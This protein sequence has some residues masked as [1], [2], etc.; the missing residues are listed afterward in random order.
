MKQIVGITMMVVVILLVTSLYMNVSG[1]AKSNINKSLDAD[2]YLP[3][4]VTS[5]SKHYSEE[6]KVPR[7]IVKY[8]KQFAEAA[9]DRGFYES[10]VDTGKGKLV[11]LPNPP[12]VTE[13]A[14][15]Y[16]IRIIQDGDDLKVYLVDKKLNQRHLLRD[17]YEDKKDADYLKNRKL[18]I[19]QVK[20]VGFR[21]MFEAHL[22]DDSLDIHE[23]EYVD[24]AEFVIDTDFQLK[25]RSDEGDLP[26]KVYYGSDF[27]I[28]SYM[29]KTDAGGSI[30]ITQTGETDKCRYDG[31]D[32]FLEND[33]D[34]GYPCMREGFL[35]DAISKGYLKTD[36]IR[37]EE[38]RF[39]EYLIE[40]FNTLFNKKY[41]DSAAYPNGVLVFPE[42]L[43][44]QSTLSEAEKDY[45][46]N[47]DVKYYSAKNE[48]GPVFFLEVNSPS[49]T[50]RFKSPLNQ[51]SEFDSMPV[52]S[53]L[54]SSHDSSSLEFVD[55]LTRL[56]DNE[57]Y[58]V[59]DNEQPAV[60]SLDKFSSEAKNNR[61]DS[62]KLNILLENNN[63]KPMFIK[64]NNRDDPV[65]LHTVYYLYN[66]TLFHIHDNSLLNYAGEHKYGICFSE[67]INTIAISNPDKKYEC[68]SFIFDQIKDDPDIV[69]AEVIT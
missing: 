22:N 30:I 48:N 20:K 37:S 65:E 18:A 51:E 32:A 9:F 25:M 34:K 14:G 1:D 58:Y 17:L 28:P 47:Y 15:D 10:R 2:Q 50:D 29:L 66:N 62:V 40:H 31:I 61:I 39:E 60:P 45:F 42:T 5:G 26:D 16:A 67:E 43:I 19:T 54:K 52:I 11:F 41:Y 64:T 59:G 44:F 13:G 8:T 4:G 6:I 69:K 49:K 38:K 27:G 53:M 57:H 24:E 63:F 23:D 35:A 46:R 21:E 3:E 56:S 7:D 12:D 55:L 68:D 36:R 33:I